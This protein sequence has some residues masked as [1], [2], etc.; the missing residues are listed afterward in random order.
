MIVQPTLI[1]RKGQQIKPYFILG[2]CL[3][4]CK[5]QISIRNKQGYLQKYKHGHNWRNKKRESRT[6]ENAAHWKGGLS[7]D[8]GYTMEYSPNHPRKVNKR[9]IRQHRFIYEEY[10]NCCL[11]RYVDIHHIDG[12]KQNNDI[13]NLRP[14]YAKDHIKIH[15]PKRKKK[16]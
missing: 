7:Y 16:L 11:L 12:N 15:K 5:T 6:G 10:Y 3:C 8:H 2:F 4:D 9:Y 14:I 13:I 1:Q